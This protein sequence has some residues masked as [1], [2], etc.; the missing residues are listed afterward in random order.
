[1]IPHTSSPYRRVHVLAALLALVVSAFVAL[2][3]PAPAMASV[4]GDEVLADWFDN[5]R[6][7]R[8]Y[9]AHC[10]EEAIDA[11]PKDL[12]DYT[13]AQEIISRALQA[14][15]RGKLAPGGVDPTPG[16]GPSGEPGTPGNPGDPGD[17]DPGDPGSEATPDVD[18]TGISSIPIPL[19]V[20]GG[21]SIMLL[22]AGG[23]GYLS[24]RRAAARDDDGAHGPDDDLL[25]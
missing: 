21:M 8:L 17:G 20:L 12:E 10:Y 15:L 4:C 7:D 3:M 11:I 23:L 19:L 2:A 22:A 24:R 6:I 9:Q 5:G 1:M 13:N 14:S 18:T 25:I 16:D